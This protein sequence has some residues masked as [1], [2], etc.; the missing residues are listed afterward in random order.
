[1][2]HVPTIL[3]FLFKVIKCVKIA[4]KKL[5]RINIH[6]LSCVIFSDI[7][8]SFLINNVQREGISED[9]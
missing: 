2:K 5:F 9:M 4:H 7:I 6:I 8:F 3:T 1:M